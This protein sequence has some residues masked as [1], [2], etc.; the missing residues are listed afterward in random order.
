[1]R[2]NY[3][4]SVSY[5]I[6]TGLFIICMIL[7]GNESL[8]QVNPPR[9][10]TLTTQSLQ[11]LNFGSFA[12]TGSGGGTITVS[13]SG[14]RSSTGDV[15]PVGSGVTYG[16]FTVEAPVGTSLYLMNSPS[17]T[18]TGSNGGSMEMTLG[19]TYPVLPLVTTQAVTE[20]HVGGT[21]TVGTSGQN[22]PGS[23]SGYYEII[24]NHE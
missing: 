21:L 2:K 16:V 8:A 10:L 13:N 12:V 15:F 5:R 22:P 19:Q 14:D 9:P 3:A 7:T 4:I 6:L 11:S 1:M 20:F 23:Y 24:I 18:L 17:A